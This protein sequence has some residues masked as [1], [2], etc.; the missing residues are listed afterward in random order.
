VGNE[1]Q[2]QQQQLLF[3]LTWIDFFGGALVFLHICCGILL[4]EVRDV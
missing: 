4:I 2:Q 3:V 1:V